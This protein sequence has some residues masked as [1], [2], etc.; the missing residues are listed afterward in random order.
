MP[1]PLRLA[2]CL[3]AASI[4]AYATASEMIVVPG[5]ADPWL[6][7]LPDGAKASGGD[8]APDQSPILTMT[9]TA[10]DCLIFRVE[11]WVS[12]TGAP[13]GPGP[14]GGATFS[15]QN[16]AENGL[17]DISAP[18]DALLG[19]FLDEAAPDSRAAPEAMS[20]NLP[21]DQDFAR[22]DPMLQQVFLVGD[23]LNAAGNRQL[24]IVPEGATRLYLGTMD[25]Y[26]WYNNTGTFRVEPELASDHP[27][28]PGRR[29]LRRP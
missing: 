18:I 24:F 11:G 16:G 5:T 9:V 29:L 1:S 15:H 19:V 4:A 13:S 3:L 22:L 21:A 27:A 25:G 12:H 20:F 10:G 8:T 23:G 17:S 14:D 2:A 26:G 6:A 7:G 28:C